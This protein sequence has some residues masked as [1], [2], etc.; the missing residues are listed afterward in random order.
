MKSGQSSE[1]WISLYNTSGYFHSQT[2]QAEKV[3][4]WA[5]Q[6]DCF[7]SDISC[8]RIRGGQYNTK[9]YTGDD[10]YLRSYYD[11]VNFKQREKC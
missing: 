4:S 6:Q 8:K 3:H 7:L 9:R 10:S 2:Q 5:A 11:G 1:E